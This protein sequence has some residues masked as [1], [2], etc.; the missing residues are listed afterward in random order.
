MD[1]ITWIT[2]PDALAA[3]FT[4]TLLEIVL[5]ID[6]IIFISILS[7]KLPEHQQAR[8]RFWGLA[9]AMFGRLALLLS[10]VWIMRLTEDLF[11]VIGMGI[12][13][14]DIILI[15][16]GLFLLVK[17]T[18]EIHDKLEGDKHDPGAGQAALTSFTRVIIQILLLDLVFSLDS[19]ITAVGMA[20]RIPVMVTAIV[21]AIG[22]MMLSAGAISRFIDQRPTVKILALSFLLMIGLALIADGLDFHI[23]KGYLYFAMAFSILVELLNLRMRKVQDQKK[24]PREL[25]DSRRLGKRL[26]VTSQHGS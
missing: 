25:G 10:L 5:G 26:R 8:A 3:L 20:D 12:S 14:K 9:L 19:V 17:A 2:E 23:P 16:G 24:R 7:S 22:V 6:N 1:W 18:H 13:G 11:H 15:A 21:I 4:L